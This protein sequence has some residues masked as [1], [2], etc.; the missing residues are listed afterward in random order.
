M[1]KAIAERKIFPMSLKQFIA[2][3]LVN[4]TVKCSSFSPKLILAAV[5]LCTSTPLCLGGHH[6]AE[7]YLSWSSVIRAGTGGRFFGGF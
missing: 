2:A 3:K 6:F 1:K 4:D 5:L 7:L